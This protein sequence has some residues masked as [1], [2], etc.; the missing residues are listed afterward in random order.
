ML[1]R[2]FITNAT[3]LYVRSGGNIAHAMLKKYCQVAAGLN[4]LWIVY[5]SG[6]EEHHWLQHQPY[7]Q[8]SFC[9]S[10][11][12]FYK[13]LFR[14][15]YSILLRLDGIC[16]I[17]TWR[18]SMF[19]SCITLFFEQH[20]SLNMW[21]TFANI[22]HDSWIV[23]GVHYNRQWCLQLLDWKRVSFKQY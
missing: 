19:N 22:R 12:F 5:R 18:M 3:S 21:W 7:G 13:S 17:N 10:C 6:S 9:F 8:F 16:F 4:L 2:C 23:I 20:V 14:V 1:R 11:F 15:P